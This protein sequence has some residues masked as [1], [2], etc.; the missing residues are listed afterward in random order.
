MAL[1]LAGL[2]AVGA[3]RAEGHGDPT[4]QAESARSRA[5]G[6]ARSA[7]SLTARIQSDSGRI[8]GLEVE[9]AAA[10]GEVTKLE[11]QLARSRAKLNALDRELRERAKEIA[12]ARRQLRI[13]QGRLAE[14][15]VAIYTS[16]EPDSIT[17]LLGAGKPLAGD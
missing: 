17:I 4:D 11:R 5:A 15:L 16:S 10:S 2:V 14:R 9:I 1:M 8:D 3:A 7:D 12:F 13:G 6:A